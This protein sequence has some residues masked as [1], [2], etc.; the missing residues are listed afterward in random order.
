MKV[1]DQGPVAWASMVQDC[2]F[3]ENCAAM[4]IIFWTAVLSLTCAEVDAVCNRDSC[5]NVIFFIWFSPRWNCKQQ[6]II[7][8][9]MYKGVY[10]DQ[11]SCAWLLWQLLSLLFLVQLDVDAHLINSFTNIFHCTLKH[12]SVYTLSW[13]FNFVFYIFSL[14]CILF[15]GWTFY[16][17]STVRGRESTTTFNQSFQLYGFYMSCRQNVCLVWYWFFMYV[18]LGVHLMQAHVRDHALHVLSH[19][20]FFN[21][22][23]KVGERFTSIAQGLDTGLFSR[24]G[25]S[26]YTMSKPHIM[27]SS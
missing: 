7:S 18:C 3:G 11:K 10:M 2:T 19:L 1:M 13:Q 24:I 16:L 15:K 27:H 21:P 8:G 23:T 5:R 4:D 17:C 14:I 12:F 20:L 22:D 6:N 26:V 25:K 9:D